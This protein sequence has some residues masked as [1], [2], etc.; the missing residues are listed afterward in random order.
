MQPL[1]DACNGCV[2]PAA[3]RP[4]RSRG[5]RATIFIDFIAEESIEEV[6]ACNFRLTPMLILKDDD[7]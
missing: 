5:G 6:S 2:S 4:S 1:R 7:S 3:P